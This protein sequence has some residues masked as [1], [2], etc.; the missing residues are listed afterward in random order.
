MPPI[1]EGIEAAQ[2]TSLN[3]L[4]DGTVAIDFAGDFESLLKSGEFDSVVLDFHSS[5]GPEVTSLRLTHDNATGETTA[6]VSENG[7]QLDGPGTFEFFAGGH[8]VFLG[9]SDGSLFREG[10]FNEVQVHITSVP[11]GEIFTQSLKGGG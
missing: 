8:A 5:D 7:L 3:P 10:G 2:P 4:P 11:G 6:T 9:W 1:I